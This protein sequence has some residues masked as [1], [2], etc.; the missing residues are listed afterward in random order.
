MAG[1]LLV[2]MPTL[3][4]MEVWWGGFT[5][6]PI[7][8]ILLLVV[9]FGVL[10]VLQHYSGLH[11]RKT[12]SGQFRAALVAM[13]IGILVSSVIL[14]AL[15]VIRSETVVSDIVG[16]IAL[17]SVS[18]SLGAS[19]AIS[20][21]GDGHPVTEERRSRPDLRPSLG[22]ALGGAM[23]FG[24]NVAT[25]DEIVILGEQLTWIHAVAIVV[26]SILLVLGISYAV[27]KSRMQIEPLSRKWLP[28]YLREAISTYV[29]ALLVGAFLLWIFGRIGTE[30]GLAPSVHMMLVLGLATTLGATAGELLV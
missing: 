19:V 11:P 23:I 7:R 25:T 15:N 18:V 26:T 10:L 28:F 24:F 8:I 6:P 16:K 2:A 30:T 1:A 14:L 22:I 9:N 5:I 27:G 21:F 17:E 12:A 20:E 13:G 4:T 29:L 3:M